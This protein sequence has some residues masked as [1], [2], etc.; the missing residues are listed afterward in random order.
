MRDGGREGY[1][2]ETA[3]DSVLRK[4]RV[5]RRETAFFA[6]SVHR[7]ACYCLQHAAFWHGVNSNYQPSVSWHWLHPGK[8]GQIAQDAEQEQNDGHAGQDPGLK[9]R[10]PAVS[11]L[12][13]AHGCLNGNCQSGRQQQKDGSIGPEG[14]YKVQAKERQAHAAYTASGTI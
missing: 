13:I 4:S 3:Q 2:L 1:C 5:S 12:Y 7:E 14:R 11:G 8:T 9:P 6:D 10:Q